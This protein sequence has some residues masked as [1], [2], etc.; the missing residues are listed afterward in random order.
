MKSYYIEYD[1]INKSLAKITIKHRDIKQPLLSTEMS[2][3]TIKVL[4]DTLGE[5]CL[6]LSYS[7]DKLI[8]KGDDN[9]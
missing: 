6:A 4:R 7:G 5:I 3:S 1:I 2:L 8:T 9:A